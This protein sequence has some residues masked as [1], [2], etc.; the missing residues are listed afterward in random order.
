MLFATLPLPPKLGSS[1]PFGNGVTQ[2]TAMSVTFAPWIVPLPRVTVQVCSG[3]AGL[4]R[5]SQLVGS[6]VVT[7]TVGIVKGPLPGL[8]DEPALLST[9]PE[10]ARPLT[11]PPIV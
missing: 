11:V 8:M 9:R 6:A 3:L 10:P 2:S 1:A 5:D 4:L 7:G